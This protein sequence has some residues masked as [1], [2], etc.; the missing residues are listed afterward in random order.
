MTIIRL[1]I[2][3]FRN[4][5]AGRMEPLADGINLI[6]GDNGSGKT[7]LIESMYYLGLGRSFR[8]VNT[9]LIQQTANKFIIS[10]QVM[11]PHNQ[12][13]SIGIERS[14]KGAVN[15]RLSGKDV[16]SMAEIV[17][18]L[19][20]QLINAHCYHLLDG[21]PHFRR[22]Y[23]DW[24]AFHYSQDFLAVWRQFKRIL[25]QRNAALANKV[26]TIELMAWND[27]MIHTALRLDQLRQTYLDQLLLVLHAMVEKLVTI[28]DLQITYYPGWNEDMT[29]QEVLSQSLQKDRQLGYT[30]FGPHRASMNVVVCRLSAKDILSRGQQKLFVCAMILAQGALL[31]HSHHKRPIYLVDDL[32]SELDVESRAKLISLLLE[33]QAQLFITAV[34]RDIFSRIPITKPVKLFHVKHGEWS[35]E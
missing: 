32:P 5:L 3:T 13:V 21:G 17:N 35:D 33:Q 19:P 15:A 29:Y 18:I 34:E 26:S 9:A 11:T 28:S 25:K 12:M 27:E 6:Y 7:S 4:I 24:G 1:D 2:T 30:Q 14:R 20:I 8:S 23:M 10:S 22:K 16:T 31:F